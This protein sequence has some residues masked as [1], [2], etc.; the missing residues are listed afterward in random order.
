MKK[1]NTTIHDELRPEYDLE[2][3]QVRR[4]GPG[5]KRFGRFV[6]PDLDR[7]FP[8]LESLYKYVEA[9]AL[10]DRRFDQ[11]QALLKKFRE[12][13]Q[14]TY[15]E[16]AEKAQWEIYFLW[17][18]LKE[19]EL[20]PQWRETDENGQVCAYPDLDLFTE[21][22][23]E[24]L[25]TRLDATDHPKL[26]ARYAHILWCSP[27]TH[28]RF[29][30]I[31][32]DSYL[33]LIQMYEQRHDE[34]ED[35]SQDISESTINAYSI[36]H[37][38]KGNVAEIKS[39]LRRLVRKLS[40][41]TPFA[42]FHFI[43]FML[44]PRKGFT[45]KDFDGLEDLCWQMAESFADDGH[46]AI[47]FL[48]LG[49]TVAQRLNQQPD[50]WGHNWTRQVALR[51]EILMQRSENDPYGA[52]FFCMNA[53]ENYKATRDEQK[54]KE[55]AQRYSELKA[56]M[57][58]GRSRID[59]DL[60]EIE[61]TCQAQAKAVVKNGTS[62]EVVRYLIWGK[63]MLPTYHEVEKAVKEKTKEFPTRRLLSKVVLDRNGNTVQRFESE[64]EK[65]HYD[66][67]ERYK[68]QLEFRSIYLIREVFFEA[69]LENKLTF[70]GLID[71]IERHCWYGKDLPKRLPDGQIAMYD[72]LDLIRPALNAYF[73]QMDFYFADRTANMPDFVLCLDS[74][75]LKIEGIFKD[76]CRRSDIGTSVRKKDKPRR[77]SVYE[78][79]LN[80]LL[81]EDAI[82][83]LFD[84]DDLLFFKF[85][86][87]ER[88][89]HNL[90]NKIAHALMSTQEY[91]FDYMHLVILALLRLGKC[92]LPEN[93]DESSTE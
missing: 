86:L 89:G 34:G 16:E 42:A 54:G 20:G 8:A 92:D 63:E 31:A 27:K 29:A 43:Q 75:T 67:L 49:K 32:I 57:K 77:N 80:A 1:G 91:S 73:R 79:D 33:T 65:E 14:K 64:E 88:C 19:S 30:E 52:L 50:N 59:V 83:H 81:H 66:I 60:T 53:I 87:V 93:N 47:K 25:T 11:A 90:R 55:L 46:R 5:R 12:A 3:L 84:E 82:E 70:E 61:K 44:K 35:F 17:F 39:E 56:A 24:Y 22:T 58:S 26:K 15:P 85:L 21:K 9:L 76:L 72:W 38:I 4:L 23:Y 36:A 7:A 62:E 18:V 51:Y 74:L 37:Q 13:N 71:F 41:G 45:K 48:E 2:K 78:K 68:Y 6:A 10:T 69:I 28:H 40:S